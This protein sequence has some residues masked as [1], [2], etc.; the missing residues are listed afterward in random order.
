[1]TGRNL[2]VNGIVEG[3]R[4]MNKDWPDI[5][6]LWWDEVGGSGRKTG[7][8]EMDHSATLSEKRSQEGPS[9]R[10]AGM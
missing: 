8:K 10:P 4:S 1:M 9:L 6:S 3:P 5:R 2:P 7:R